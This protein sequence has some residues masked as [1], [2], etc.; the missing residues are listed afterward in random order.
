MLYDI[1]PSKDITGGPWYTDQE[2]DHEFIEELCKF[3]VQY[4]QMQG[5]VSVGA[6]NERVRIS[7]ISKVSKV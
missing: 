2:F 7:G 4:V 5:M 6:I 1:L 3:I